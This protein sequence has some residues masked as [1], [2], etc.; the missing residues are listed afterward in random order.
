MMKLGGIIALGIAVV[1]ASVAIPVTVRN[2]PNLMDMRISGEDRVKRA[3]SLAEGEVKQLCK[4]AGVDYPPK[5][6][7]IRAFKH[8]RELEIW[9]SNSI[10]GEFFKLQTFRVAGQSGTLGPKRREGDLQVPE[11]SYQVNRFNPQSRFRLSLGLDYPNASDRVRSDK[12][13]PGGDIFI[14]GDT[15]S[16]GCL[17]MTDEK[18]DQIY[19]LALQANRAGLAPI[20]VHIFPFRMTAE[21][22]S[23]QSAKNPGHR[24]FWREIK[25]IFDHFER[26]RKPPVV[27]VGPN[28]AYSLGK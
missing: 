13:K 2:W 26:H 19:I 14:H 10:A 20:Y 21:N 9:G 6:I 7:F 25:P 24:E 22:L 5:R 3:F 11:G 8:E 4:S 16:I 1:A 18:I 27:E 17:A 15:R 23:A 28:G 12:S